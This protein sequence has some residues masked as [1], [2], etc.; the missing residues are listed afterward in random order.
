V[1]HGHFKHAVDAHNV[2]QCF[3][4]EFHVDVTFKLFVLFECL[5]FFSKFTSESFLVMRDL[6][7]V[8]ET[9]VNNWFLECLFDVLLLA[10]LLVE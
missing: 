2:L 4:L 8:Y 1:P 5:E 7:A 9:C 3:V 10:K 6:F